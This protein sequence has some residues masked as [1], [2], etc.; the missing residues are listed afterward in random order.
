[1]KRSGTPSKPRFGEWRSNTLPDGL[2]ETVDRVDFFTGVSQ[3]DIYT[4]IGV[5]LYRFQPDRP[6]AVEFRATV[7]DSIVSA[8]SPGVIALTL[9]N[10]SQSAQQVFSGTVPPFGMVGADAVD[11]GE[12]VLLWRNYEQ[13]GCIRFT[14]VLHVGSVPTPDGLYC[15]GRSRVAPRR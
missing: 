12:E 6:P 8:D 9:V 2:A 1:M 3:D 11:A 7:V 10:T 13:E 4:H 5:T 15:S 14:P